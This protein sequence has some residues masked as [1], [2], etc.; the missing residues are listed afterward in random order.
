MARRVLSIVKSEELCIKLATETPAVFRSKHAA[1]LSYKGKV[2]ATGVNKLKTH[3]L[4]LRY[5]KHPDCRNLHAEI[6]CIIRAINLYGTELLR[7]CTLYVA[8]TRK[9]GTTAS[10]KPCEGCARAI[11]AFGIKR[12][13]YTT[14]EGWTIF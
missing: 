4:M 9:D 6:D 10:S 1:V 14:K 12:T 7:E 3:P 5:N 13:Y 2:L 11:K 8:R